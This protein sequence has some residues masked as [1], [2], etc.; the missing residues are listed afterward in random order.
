MDVGGVIALGFRSGIVAVF[1]FD[2]ELKALLGS[3][4]RIMKVFF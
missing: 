4:S 1:G 2:Q 3:E